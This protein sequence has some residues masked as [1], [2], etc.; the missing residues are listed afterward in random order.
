MPP[1]M[2]ELDVYISGGLFSLCAALLAWLYSVMR[3]NVNIV[4]SLW[5]IMFLLIALTYFAGAVSLGWRA[6]WIVALCTVWALR[7]SLHLSWRNYGKAED[8]RYQAIRRN[9]SPHFAWK[10]LYI[11]FGLQAV[12]AWI[13][14]LPLVAAA[15]GPAAPGWLDGLGLALWLIGMS[16]ES[17]ADW[18]LAHFKTRPENRGRVLDSGLWR[19]SRHPNYFGEACVWWGFYCLAAAAGAWWT[20]PAPLIMTGLLLKVSGVSLLERDIA[21]RRPAYRQY[22]RQTNAFIPGPPRH[23][24]EHSTA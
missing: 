8:R 7:L 5:S 24:T 12:L 15:A 14:S 19:Y 20:L 13:I 9:H 21:D 1:S 16:F 18:Q 17:V 22:I 11:V 6:P 2:I 4:D 23:S 3:S 10:S